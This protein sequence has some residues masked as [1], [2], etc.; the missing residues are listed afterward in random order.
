MFHEGTPED[1]CQLGKHFRRISKISMHGANAQGIMRASQGSLAE[2]GMP[3]A[4]THRRS[5]VISC[6][7][8]SLRCKTLECCSDFCRG[9]VVERERG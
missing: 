7:N 5:E 8:S 1:E 6:C 2:Y 9:S 4:A 3:G